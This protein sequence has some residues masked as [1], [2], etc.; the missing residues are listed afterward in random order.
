MGM[1]NY[2]TITLQNQ[3]PEAAE[4]VPAIKTLRGYAS[5][6]FHLVHMSRKNNTNLFKH[7]LRKLALVVHR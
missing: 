1:Q 4:E 7:I 6:V 2:E 5:E 3:I